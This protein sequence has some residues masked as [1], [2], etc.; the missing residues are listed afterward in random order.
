MS[1]GHLLQL[2]DWEGVVGGETGIRT[3][4]TLSG[5]HAFQACSFGHSDISPRKWQEQEYIEKVV[6]KQ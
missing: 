2:S 3:P 4:V 6:E 5:K 1:P